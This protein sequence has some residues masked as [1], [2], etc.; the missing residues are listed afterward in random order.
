MVDIGT[1]VEAGRTPAAGYDTGTQ[2]GKRY[3]TE[4]P[5][6]GL[7]L[8][9]TKGGEGALSDGETALVFKEAKPLPSSD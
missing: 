6:D 2:L 3:T 1:D 7:E 5:T 4:N 9:A 8:L